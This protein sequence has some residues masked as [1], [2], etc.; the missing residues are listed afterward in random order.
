MIH[1]R[2][3]QEG[4]RAFAGFKQNRSGGDNARAPWPFAADDDS[5][6]FF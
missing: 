2:T 4:E 1:S 6:I 3:A 5:G